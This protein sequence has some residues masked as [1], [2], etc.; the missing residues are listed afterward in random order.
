MVG[1]D[2][3][4]PLPWLRAPLGETLQRHRGHAL[5][6][7]GAPGDG[8]WDFVLA[9]AQGWLCESAAGAARPCGHC[10]ACRLFRDLTHPDMG[11]LVPQELALQ[12]GW[13]V[14]VDSGRKP[15][16]QIRVDE[17]RAVIDR[18]TSTSGRGAGRALV[19]F[20]GE[21]MNAVA[22]SA[23][24]KTLEEPPPGTRIVI[25]AAE[26]ARLLP[27]IRSRCQVLTLARPTTEQATA[28]LAAEGVGQPAVLLAACAGRPLEARALHRAGL[29]AEAWTDLPTRLARGDAG[30][31]SGLGPPAVLDALAKLCHDAMCAAVGAA[32]RFFIEAR[33]RQPLQLERLSLWHQNLQRLQ[34]HADHPW[35]EPLLTDALVAEGVDALKPAAA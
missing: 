29:T 28:W 12:R 16:K 17:V 27:T 25:A 21:A 24:L 15:S 10:T 1:P 23:L 7:H 33:F 11:W 30:G 6:V 35:N 14:Q 2:G 20:P 26:P 9:L 5:L 34:R 32:P 3:F 4:F 8:S 19:I 18:M 22:A 13:P 31:L